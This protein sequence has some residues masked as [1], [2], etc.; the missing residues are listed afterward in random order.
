MWDATLRLF[1]GNTPVVRLSTYLSA[2]DPWPKEKE[3]VVYRLRDLTGGQFN[4]NVENLFE[5]FFEILILENIF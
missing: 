1:L 3:G 4:R 5:T 2:R